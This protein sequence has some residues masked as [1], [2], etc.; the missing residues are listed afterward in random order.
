MIY[1][2]MPQMLNL[3]RHKYDICNF[4]CFFLTSVVVECLAT[5]DGRC[6]FAHII[7][8]SYCPDICPQELEKQTRVIELL[9]TNTMRTMLYSSS[10][11]CAIQ[12]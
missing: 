11:N 10:N 2:G 9:G 1:F 8:F 6:M 3:W 12:I 7:G 5:F 4:F